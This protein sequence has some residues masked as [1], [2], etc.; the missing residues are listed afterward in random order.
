[1]ILEEKELILSHIILRA[2]VNSQ[3]S[4]KED[5]DRRRKMC[6]FTWARTLFTLSS[7]KKHYDHHSLLVKRKEK[8]IRKL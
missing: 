8:E 5:Q 2:T 6:N 7:Y 3:A 1:M 4:I